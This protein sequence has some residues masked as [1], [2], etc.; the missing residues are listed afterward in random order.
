MKFYLLPE[1]VEKGKTRAFTTG[2]SSSRSMSRKSGLRTP[3]NFFLWN[4]EPWA[5]ESGIQLKESG[6]LLKLGIQNPNFTDKDRNPVP[7]IRNPGRGIQNPWLSLHGVTTLPL[8]RSPAPLPKKKKRQKE[9]RCP[10]LMLLLLYFFA[11]KVSWSE[12]FERKQ[13]TH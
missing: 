12:S 1:I 3:G 8:A 6:I 9:K 4:P 11:S 13:W 10:V 7:G 2:A 5:L